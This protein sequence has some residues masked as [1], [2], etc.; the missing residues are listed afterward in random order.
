MV[1]IPHFFKTCPKFCNIQKADIR[2]VYKMTRKKIISIILVVSVF[3][4]G[5]ISLLASSHPDGLEWSILKTSGSEELTSSG[6]I[7]EKVAE[8]QDN[9]SF[10]S[11]L[12]NCITG[13]NKKQ[14]H[15][16]QKNCPCLQSAIILI[17]VPS[18]TFLV[19][20][21]NVL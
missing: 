8:V 14:G 1:Q 15:I 7:Y 9:T 2:K 11:P 16:F 18:C 6:E 20:Y 12:Y 4:A 21:H 5:G 19:K 17:L 10:L 13:T 3:V